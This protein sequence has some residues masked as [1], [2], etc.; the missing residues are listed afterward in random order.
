MQ[1]ADESLPT[2]DGWSGG[3]PGGLGGGEICGGGEGGGGDGGGNGGG[4]GSGQSKARALPTLDSE[5]LSVYKAPMPTTN[6]L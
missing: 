2:Q 3:A 5:F 4:D 1:I 6:P